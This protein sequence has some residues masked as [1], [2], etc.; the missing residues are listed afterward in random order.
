MEFLSELREITNV[1]Y[2]ELSLAFCSPKML[3]SDIL[4]WLE[5]KCHTKQKAFV[6]F[7]AESKFYNNYTNKF[8]TFDPNLCFKSVTN[9]N[10]ITE[11]HLTLLSIFSYSLESL[12]W[13]SVGLCTHVYTHMPETFSKFIFIIF[14]DVY[15]HY[16]CIVY[17]SLGRCQKHQMPWSWTYRH[18]WVSWEVNSI[19]L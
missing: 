6:T 1:E 17:A 8:E 19:L 18:L 5:F 7:C 10:G 14:N 3:A 9:T 16:E 11:V 13:S 2:L 4:M 15:V 12:G